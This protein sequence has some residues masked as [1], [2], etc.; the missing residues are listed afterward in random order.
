MSKVMIPQ[1]LSNHKDLIAIPRAAFEDFVAWQKKVK[2][3][4]T[5]MPSNSERKLLAS[6][7]KSFSRGS[8]VTI[9]QLEDGLAASR[10]I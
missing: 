1:G 9:K 4:K 6:A 3:S 5:F 2:S 8:Y 10:K 7:R